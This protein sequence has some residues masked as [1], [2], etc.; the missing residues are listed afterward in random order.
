MNIL[1]LI[2]PKISLRQ[3]Q[4]VRVWLRDAIV[5]VLSLPSDD[6]H[7]LICVDC[8]SNSNRYRNWS[9]LLGRYF[10]VKGWRIPS[11]YVYPPTSCRDQVTW[12]L[13]NLRWTTL[14]YPAS[15]TWSLGIYLTIYLLRPCLP[16]RQIISTITTSSLAIVNAHRTTMHNKV[17]AHAA[18]SRVHMYLL[19]ILQHVCTQMAVDVNRWIKTPVC[20]T[21]LPWHPYTSSTKLRVSFQNVEHVIAL[22]HWC[23]LHIRALYPIR[24][25]VTIYWKKHCVTEQIL[26]VPK[27]LLCLFA[28]GSSG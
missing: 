5:I 22:T 20:E 18:V 21:E 24:G 6:W 4:T 3:N 9:L 7:D 19:P 23:L 26:S 25:D 13:Y 10:V 1:S 12:S 28:I 27:V 17:A 11:Y 2:G 8:N 16:Y 14:P 15:I